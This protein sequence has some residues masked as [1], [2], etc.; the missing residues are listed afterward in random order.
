MGDNG[1]DG[2]AT[3]VDR[4]RAG[5][6]GRDVNKA[7]F[8]SL[9]TRAGSRSLGN[10]VLERREGSPA[11]PPAPHPLKFNCAQGVAATPL[12][13]NVAATTGNTAVMSTVSPPSAAFGPVFGDADPI[14]RS[15][16]PPCKAGANARHLI[17]PL[18][19]RAETPSFA[20]SKVPSLCNSRAADI[21][22]AAMVV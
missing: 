10:K 6:A 20:H 7:F 2:A 22:L 3:F 19:V 12:S 1:P 8:G 17:R 18:R 5:L 15:H 13:H 14:D 9:Q 11:V 16:G 4:L 21:R